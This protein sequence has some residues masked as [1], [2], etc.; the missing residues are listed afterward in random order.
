MGA[1]RL[2]RAVVT[3]C[4]Y[5][6][7]P[8]ASAVLA[9]DGETPIVS[10]GRVDVTGSHIPRT[11]AENALPIQ[12]LTREDI[13]RSGA[14]TVA[15]LMS[16][17]P[18]NILA[19]ND[20]LSAGNQIEPFPRPGLSSI[21][22]RGI[23]AGSTLVLVNGRR[24]ANYA[25]DGG[26][27]DV[28]SI[29]LSAVDRVEILKDG[30]SAI[31]GTDA[32]AGVVNFILRN[33]FQGAQASASGNWTQHG[34]GDQWQT[35]ATVGHGDLARDRFNAFASA[36][37][38]KD[39]ALRA[40]DR[41]FTRSGFRPEDGLVNANGQS[42]PANVQRGRDFTGSPAFASGCAPPQS[43]AVRL[44]G[45]DVCVADP[46]SVADLSPQVERTT[47]F[48]RAT[49]ALRP[50]AQ[51][52][53]EAGY[54][55]DR[56]VFSNAPTP[57]YHL[58]AVGGR[59]FVY[60]AGGPFYPT[61][62]AADNGLAG[63]LE[64]RYRTA[65]LGNRVNQVTTRALRIVA[66]AE[67]TARGWDYGTAV[68]YSETRQD[69]RF[70]S[71]YVS[72]A[73]LHDVLATGLVNPFGPSGPVGDALLASTGVSGDFHSAKGSTWLV[74]AKASRSLLA[75]RGGPLA[76]AFGGE[77]RRESLD[78]RFAPIAEL[79]DVLGAGGDHHSV[80]EGRTVQALYVEADVPFLAG[81]E[82]QLA[83]R[84]DHYGDFG[85]T[86]NP[87]IALRWQP[88]R[89]LLLRA[90][91]GMGFRAPTLYDL[92]APVQHGE[93]SPFFA[94]PL[95][96]PVTGHV[97]DCGAFPTIFGGNPALQPET[98]EQSNAGIVWEPAPGLALTLDYWNLHKHNAIGTLDEGT[99]LG[100]VGR[101]GANV[102]RG[103]VDPT[104]PNLPGPITELV[105]VNQN[106]GNL[107]TSGYDVAVQWRGVQTRAGTFALRLDGTYIATFVQQQA[108]GSYASLVGNNDFGAVPRWRHYA[109]LD[110]THGAW[111]ATLA[112]AFQNGYDE[113]DERT[114]N[115]DGCGRRRVGSY[116]TWDV[117]LQYAGVPHAAVVVGVKNLFDRTPPF[118]Q[119][120]QGFANGYEA[121][122]AD[123][124]GRT[125]YA[126]LTMAF[127]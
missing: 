69:D 109:S 59:P 70:A 22:L 71:G 104:F 106:I 15:E 40:A 73:R 53:T 96:C 95:R 78:N 93:S 88:L 41:P 31:Y 38:T 16:T 39:F 64:L 83:A 23:G 122:S 60:P 111:S 94:D 84:Y 24:V 13:E 30:A 72:D 33:D 82:A 21:N 65:P 45:S 126:R 12:V 75:L 14:S 37:Y 100:D 113:I 87:K 102:V 18:A 92:Y 34:G 58:F 79:G 118:T 44:Q 108:D 26:A 80:A 119:L 123:P 47:V 9:Q 86:T 57:A 43:L 11:D 77:A 1:R 127:N 3:A 121:Q 25:F 110:W 8:L 117:Q 115:D 101:W 35:V 56:F 29:P 98:S 20:R 51:L 91:W 63:N 97:D 54:A 32:I 66:G 10:L 49:W 67:G 46:Q 52:F 2:R 19:F 62:F 76:I 42:F 107:R 68:L 27:V 105:L 81:V 7:L 89:V 74:D 17:L 103:P 28:N 6:C 90:S 5:A 125:F 85:G 116:S 114:C 48:G 55:Y 124:R 112:Q 99:V 36:T 120:G 4:G 61:A 50:E